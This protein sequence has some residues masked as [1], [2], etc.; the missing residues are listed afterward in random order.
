M[1]G[2]CFADAKLTK[3]TD[4]KYSNSSFQ[5]V[6]IHHRYQPRSRREINAQTH[7]KTTTSRTKQS[8]EYQEN[9][10]E[11]QEKS[12]LREWGSKRDTW[13]E[14][15]HRDQRSAEKYLNT[16][17]QVR[18][19]AS[20]NCEF[21]FRCT[22]LFR[23]IK[24]NHCLM[25]IFELIPTVHSKPEKL[26]HQKFSHHTQ[27]IIPS[28]SLNLYLPTIVIPSSHPPKKRPPTSQYQT[29]QET[30][31]KPTND[32]IPIS[33]HLLKYSLHLINHLSI[34]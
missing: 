4:G 16:T 14:I 5:R 15:L 26:T 29:T 6:P 3:L 24:D 9:C 27:D 17:T 1:F 10:D 28:P 30:Q 12:N 20:C 23:C 13:A 33:I 34:P 7:A 18:S 11:K 25:P 32:P 21:L 8:L 22:I 19:R 2:V 31:T